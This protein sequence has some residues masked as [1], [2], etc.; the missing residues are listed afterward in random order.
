[1]FSFHFLISSLITSQQPHGHVS[2][3]VLCHCIV[4]FVEC[5]KCR[6]VYF[7]S[8]DLAIPNVGW[9]YRDNFLKAIFSPIFCVVYYVSVCSVLCVVCVVCVLVCSVLCVC[10]VGN[11]EAV[12]GRGGCGSGSLQP[13][14]TSGQHHIR[15]VTSRQ[16][17]ASPEGRPQPSTA[18]AR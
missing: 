2:C 6:D 4:E 13:G 7:V 15:P 1:M 10:H 3:V 17:A 8:C 14:H 12:S 9:G 16:P 11:V 18:S 5:F